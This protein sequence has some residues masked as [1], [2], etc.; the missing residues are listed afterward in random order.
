MNSTTIATALAI[1]KS[2]IGEAQQQPIM[3]QQ[4][5]G[6]T[7]VNDGAIRKLMDKV[8]QLEVNAKKQ[9]Q[10]RYLDDRALH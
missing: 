7:S 2:M 10:V 1:Y 5:G 6:G 4:P 8:N 3:V 9:G